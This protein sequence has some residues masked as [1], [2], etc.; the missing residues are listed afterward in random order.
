MADQF[1]QAL[2]RVNSLCQ[3]L[4]C[5]VEKSFLA[6]IRT[7]MAIQVGLDS[8]PRAPYVDPLLAGIVRPEVKFPG[9]ETYGP[10][11]AFMV[12]PVTD[13][14]A[15]TETWYGT[16][17][18]LGK[19]LPLEDSGVL[20]R[21]VSLFRYDTSINPETDKL[22]RILRERHGDLPRVNQD[23]VTNFTV[24]DLLHAYEQEDDTHFSNIQVQQVKVVIPTN[25]LYRTEAVGLVSNQGRTA[26]DHVAFGYGIGETFYRGRPILTDFDSGKPRLTDVN[27]QGKMA[28]FNVE[29]LS[30]VQEGVADVKAGNM[31]IIALPLLAPE[32]VRLRRDDYSDFGLLRGGGSMKSFGGD[33]TLGIDL[34]ALS[35]GRSTGQTSIL[36]TTPFDPS[37]PVSILDV[38]LLATTPERI[39]YAITGHDRQ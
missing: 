15:S 27:Q 32:P 6:D 21:K 30:Q 37:R 26:R 25:P 23:L 16:P 9:S 11:F 28:Y 18:W 8:V 3:T 24:A 36:V 35:T 22:T 10:A 2:E 17:M 14:G 12:R 7:A 38:Q 1:A 5:A 33:H 19:V 13:K 20:Q 29:A 4:P 39:P 31:V 34:A